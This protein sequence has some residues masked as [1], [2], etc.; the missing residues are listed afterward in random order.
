MTRSSVAL[1]T[2]AM[3]CAFF[4]GCVQG[5]PVD[6]APDTVNDP[7]DGTGSVPHGDDPNAD[8]NA[9]RKA[10]LTA[11]WLCQNGH[12][13]EVDDA[14]TTAAGGL[15]CRVDV[16]FDANSMVISS[17]GIPNH[18]LESGP[19]CCASEGD[20]TWNL[21]LTPVNDTDGS[22]EAAPL[23]G[24]IAVAVNGAAIYGPEDGPGG[25]AVAAHSGQ[26]VEDRQPIWLGL[27]H[28][29]A[30]PG[31]QY[32]YHADANCIHWHGADAEDEGW[33]AYAFAKVDS[34]EHSKVIGFAFDGYPLYGSFGYAADGTV[35]E[36]TSS[37]RLRD[38]MTGSGGIADYEFVEGLGDLDECNG[39][40]TATPD[41]PEGTYAYHSTM[42]NGNG[43]LG[44]PYFLYCYRGVADA[45]NYDAGGGGPPGGGG[46]GGGGPPPR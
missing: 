35:K 46:P 34:S 22:F 29:H 10:A 33:D 41:F 11:L 13:V 25:D 38:G 19:G 27:C 14:N 24:P 31:G 8:A 37:Y 43:D 16:A 2:L 23:R 6:D 17:S 26:Y 18:D 12:E 5:G 9:E 20:Y 28:A 4:A 36:M 30:G 44:F 3:A 15:T 40:W 42:T 39:H 7:V 45:S 32:H 21:P 1:L